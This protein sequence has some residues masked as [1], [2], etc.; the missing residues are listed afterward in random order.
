MALIRCAETI[1]YEASTLPATQ[2][3]QK[4]LPEQITKQQQCRSR[5]D[6]GVELDRTSLQLLGVM[7][8]ELPGH[9][10]L[11]KRRAAAEGRAPLSYYSQA[12]RRYL[13]G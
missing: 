5:L 12:H 3:S 9:H 11:E 13:D 8:E 2:M 1:Q 4:V 6:G 7:E 10:V